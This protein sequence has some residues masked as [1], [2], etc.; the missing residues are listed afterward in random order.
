M[1]C[2]CITA[3]FMRLSEAWHFESLFSRFMIDTSLVLYKGSQTTSSKISSSST[4]YHESGDSISWIYGVAKAEN[5]GLGSEFM[6]YT[7]TSRHLRRECADHQNDCLRCLTM[8]FIT[9]SINNFSVHCAEQLPIRQP[10]HLH[11]RMK[12][13]E[14][15]SWSV[16]RITF[17]K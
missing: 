15:T 11:S 4:W 5:E 10:Q 6:G 17:A 13:L 3:D 9:S 7:A 8:H 2:V 1:L 12:A 14:L 16:Y